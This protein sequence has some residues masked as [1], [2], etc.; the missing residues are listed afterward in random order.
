[1]GYRDQDQDACVDSWMAQQT[2]Q[3]DLGGQEGAHDW[4]Q[5]QQ[6]EETVEL[7][8]T[9]GSATAAFYCTRCLCFTTQTVY[10]DDEDVVE[11]G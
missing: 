11:T 7:P 5:M 10:L 9:G 8:N 2:G 3:A 6:D 1:M 4:R